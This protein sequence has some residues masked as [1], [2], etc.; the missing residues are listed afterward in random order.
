VEIKKK[1][2]PERQRAEMNGGVNE[3]SMEGKGG[4]GGAVRDGEMGA[5]TEAAS[6]AAVS[7]EALRKRM[8]DF[9]RERDWEQFHSPRNLLLALV[10]PPL[11]SSFPFSCDLHGQF[12]FVHLEIAALN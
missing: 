9:A 2:Q 8:A 5:A 11:Y 7:L 1:N 6:V 10:R 12:T 3:V 4:V